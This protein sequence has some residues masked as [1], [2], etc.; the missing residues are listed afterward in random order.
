VE[1]GGGRRRPHDEQGGGFLEHG[2]LEE[3]DLD[4][5]DVED[6]AEVA[7]LVRGVAGNNTALVRGVVTAAMLGPSAA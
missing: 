2:I 6:C 4:D 7:A 3:G 5:G 1:L